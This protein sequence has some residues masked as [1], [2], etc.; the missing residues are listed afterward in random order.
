MK[1]ESISSAGYLKRTLKQPDKIENQKSDFG[2]QNSFG[3]KISDFPKSY[4]KMT[5]TFKASLAEEDAYAREI[6]EQQKIN[7]YLWAKSWDADRARVEYDEKIKNEIARRDAG[8]LFYLK[9]STIQAVKNKYNG[10]YDDEKKLYDKMM[11]PENVEYCERLLKERIKTRV[12]TASEVLR[13]TKGSIDSKIAGYS[14][15]KN[16]M[17]EVFILPVTQE[18]LDGGEK[19]VK[20]AILLAGPTGCGKTVAAEAIANETYC[21]VD[22][23]KTNTDPNDFRWVLRGKIGEA[24]QRYIEKQKEIQ[25]FRKSPEFKSMSEE[26]RD[27]KLK[28]LGSPRTVI[29]IDEF[30]RY[31]N[32]I[33]VKPETIK[34]NVDAVKTMFDGCAEFP[35]E[36]NS[37]AAAVTFICTTNYPKRIPV[38]EDIN[39]NKLTPYA[40]LPPAGEDMEDVIRHYMKKGNMLMYDYRK[41]VDKNLQEID[42]KNINLKKFVQKFGPSET[43]GAF[44]NDAIGSMVIKAVEAYIDNPSFDFNIYLLREFKYAIKDIRPEKLKTYQDELSRLGLLDTIKVEKIDY[45]NNSRKEIV[46]KKIKNLT[47]VPE[48]FLTPKQKEELHALRAELDELNNN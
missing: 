9:K 1:I 14:A 40:V 38:G 27:K 15:L 29:I 5:H 16:D 39:I 45:D 26:Q 7:D 46:E 10:Y 13:N 37:N 23:I 34:E 4:I 44:S 25:D 24:K 30:D 31:F 3:Q 2:Y 41:Q 48:E 36:E 22:R 17:K 21:F 33:S 8:A 42:V 12:K 11:K 35:K 20:N 6:K 43:D 19:K 47:I 28:E 32:P 18:V